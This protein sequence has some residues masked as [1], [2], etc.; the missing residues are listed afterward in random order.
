MTTYTTIVA[1][2]LAAVALAGCATTDVAVSADHEVSAS[3]PPTSAPTSSTLP[4]VTFDPCRDISDAILVRF[5][6]DVTER[7][8]HEFSIG[9]EDIVA[10]N[11]QGD[12]RAVGFVAQNSPWESIPF[13]VSPQSITVNGREAW[14]APA[15]LD[16]GSCSVLM[17]TD[18]GAVIINNNPAMGRR[19]DPNIDRCDGIM[20]IAEAIEPLIDDGA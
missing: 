20:E 19:A 8:P 5:G 14:Y 17:R 7:R 9:S 2:A 13:Q 11:V 18:F 4:A 10:C 12:E 16:D 3:T 15:G 1:A 6:L